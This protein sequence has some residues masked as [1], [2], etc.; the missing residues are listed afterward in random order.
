MFYGRVV[1]IKG[2]G[3]KGWKKELATTNKEWDKETLSNA[4]CLYCPLACDVVAVVTVMVSRRYMIH[5]KIYRVHFMLVIVY[6]GF[7]QLKTTRLN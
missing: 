2:K 4:K 3:R 7:R 5:H 1:V 6:G